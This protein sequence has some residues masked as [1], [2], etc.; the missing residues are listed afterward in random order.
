MSGLF[1]DMKN[2]YTPQQLIVPS[3]ISANTN[4]AGADC[5][6]GGATDGGF[7]ILEVGAVTALTSLDVQLKESDTSGGTYTAMQVPASFP[8]VT[9][10]NKVHIIN[11]HRSKKFVRAELTIVGTS[12]VCAVSIH[13]ERK[14]P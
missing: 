8:T 5:D 13:N 2:H 12:A 14:D 9:V 3:T 7:A 1:T 4:S 10:A 6:L 11:F